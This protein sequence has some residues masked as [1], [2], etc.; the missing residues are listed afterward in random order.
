[1]RILALNRVASSLILGLAL[2]SCVSLFHDSRPP[3]AG[4]KQ[5]AK[6]VI[7]QVSETTE[8]ATFKRARH[9][10]AGDRL[11]FDKLRFTGSPLD[12]FHQVA[13]SR[14]KA[15]IVAACSSR[16]VPLR[17]AGAGHSEKRRCPY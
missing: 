12:P 13:R 3:P 16:S 1:M 15:E 17:S 8:V 14:A 5:Q 2:S 9:G 4:T 10:G 11:G 7:S 6:P